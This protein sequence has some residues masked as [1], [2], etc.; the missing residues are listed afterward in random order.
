MR[1]R[2]ELDGL[3]G[4]AV[5]IVLAAHTRLAGFAIEGGFAGVQLFFALSG[6][7]ITSILVAELGSHGHV[8]LR[9][10]YVR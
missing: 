9:A 10:F 6:F 2:P 8:D 1:H 3:R 7:L 5:L 4:I